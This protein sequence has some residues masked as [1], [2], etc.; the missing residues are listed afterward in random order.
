MEIDDQPLWVPPDSQVYMDLWK[1]VE[2]QDL[3][4]LTVALQPDLNINNLYGSEDDMEGRTLLHLAAEKGNAEVV[5]YLLDH[6][7]TVDSLSV[8]RFGS[9]TPLHIAASMAHPDVLTILL[10]AGADI[11]KGDIQAGRGGNALHLVL[12]RKTKIKQQHVD[13]INLLLDHGIDIRSRAEWEPEGA[14][15]VG[16]SDQSPARIK[17][18]AN[19]MKSY[20]MQFDWEV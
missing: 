14:T 3:D 4:A 7:A 20:I 18:D 6:G 11:N 19:E 15:I 5:R 13:T 8:D 1:A 16:Y 9:E 10:D 17:V 2:S 12:L